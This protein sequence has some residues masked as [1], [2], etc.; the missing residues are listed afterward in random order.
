MSRKFDLVPLVSFDRH[1]PQE[2][3]NI[4]F[5]AGNGEA[6]SRILHLL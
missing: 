3:M 6:M 1:F 5:A 4:E 2:P